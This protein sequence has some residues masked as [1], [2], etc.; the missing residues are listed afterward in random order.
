MIDNGLRTTD[1]ASELIEMVPAD[2][3]WESMVVIMDHEPDPAATALAIRLAQRDGTRVILFD[4]RAS[5]RWTSPFPP[6]E[7]VRPFLLDEAGI[8]RT[9]R[10]VVADAVRDL[11]RAGVQASAHLS[12]SR[13]SSDLRELVATQGVTLVA[14]P[15]PLAGPLVH[16]VHL[17]RS[18]GAHLLLSARG[19]RPQMHAPLPPGGPVPVEQRIQVRFLIGVLVTFIA[20]GLRNRTSS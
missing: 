10:D 6:G 3:P 1:G 17:A 19:Q 16:N 18:A 8:R 2:H 4:A 9:G 15:V 13:H 5:S 14:C 7:N 11:Q 20:A 12:S